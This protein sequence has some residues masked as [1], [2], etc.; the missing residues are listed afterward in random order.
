MKFGMKDMHKVLLSICKFHEN[1]P[2]EGRTFLMGVNKI[3][4]MLVPLICDVAWFSG[5]WSE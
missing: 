4:C 2:K 5:V 1:W 3:I